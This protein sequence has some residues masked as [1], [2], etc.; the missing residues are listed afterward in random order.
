MKC[1]VDQVVLRGL[2]ETLELSN[3][4]WPGFDLLRHGEHL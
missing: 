2:D 4:L 1:E 3:R